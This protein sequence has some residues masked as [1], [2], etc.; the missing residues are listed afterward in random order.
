MNFYPVYRLSRANG[1]FFRIGSLLGTFSPCGNRI[2][3]QFLT[4]LMAQF[5]QKAGDTILLGPRCGPTGM[6][7]PPG[8]DR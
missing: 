1:S 5:E 7:A 6:D 8:E 4:Q 2:T 3:P